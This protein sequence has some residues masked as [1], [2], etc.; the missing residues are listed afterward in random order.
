[1]RD[2]ISV[3]FG[4][5]INFL[6]G[7]LFILETRLNTRPTP[8]DNHQ[9]ST[10][11]SSPFPVQLIFEFGASGPNQIF[12]HPQGSSLTRNND[13]HWWCHPHQ[14]PFLSFSSQ[15]HSTLAPFPDVVQPTAGV[16]ETVSAKLRLDGTHCCSFIQK[17]SGGRGLQLAIW[18]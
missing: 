1:M 4:K 14:N 15:W 6:T 16:K 5:G 2:R 10:L 7:V 18:S 11:C 9:I 8:R 17:Q 3:L 13:T 12:L